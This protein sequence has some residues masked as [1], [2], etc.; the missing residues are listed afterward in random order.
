MDIKV[1]LATGWPVLLPMIS[2]LCL[3][4]RPLKNKTLSV[5][6]KPRPGRHRSDTLTITE[7]K[8]NCAFN[9][10]RS[11]HDDEKALC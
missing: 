2:K 7:E 9:F 10:K 1:D 8:P 3:Q 11:E 5:W 4:F 6:K